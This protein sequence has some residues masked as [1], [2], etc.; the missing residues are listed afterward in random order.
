M[1]A[2]GKEVQEYLLTE[3]K[4][5]KFSFEIKCVA[6][7]CPTRNKNVKSNFKVTVQCLKL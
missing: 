1:Q 2:Q 6:A 3:Q 4:Y 7:I 5:Y